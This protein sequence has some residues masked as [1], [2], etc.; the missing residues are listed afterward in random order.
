MAQ[1]VLRVV[2][3][4]EKDNVQTRLWPNAA[5]SQLFVVK[6]VVKRP[7]RRVHTAQSREK[8]HAL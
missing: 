6:V 1:A 5:P 2:F 8:S 7:L 3:V 4:Q